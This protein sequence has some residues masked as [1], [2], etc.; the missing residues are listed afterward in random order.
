MI[1]QVN[2]FIETIRKVEEEGKKAQHD[3]DA[4]AKLLEQ[5][6]SGQ[7]AVAQK[8]KPGPDITPKLHAAYWEAVRSDYGFNVSLEHVAAKKLY[9]VAMTFGSFVSMTTALYRE[10]QDQCA[11]SRESVT[12]LLSAMG[13]TNQYDSFYGRMRTQGQKSLEQ[14]FRMWVLRFDTKFGSTTKREHEGLLWK[15]GTGV[16]HSWAQRYFVLSDNTLSYH[17]GIEDCDRREGELSLLCTTVKPLPGTGCFTIISPTKTYTLRAMTDYDRDEWIAVIQNNIEFL[18]NNSP[19]STPHRRSTAAD[20]WSPLSSEANQICADCG[21]ANPSWCCINWGVCVCIHCCGV[22]RSLTT[23]V[24]KPRSLTLDR[25]DAPTQ[26]IFD[27]IGNARANSILE[28]KVGDAKITDRATREEREAFIKRK[29]VQR[30]FVEPTPIDALQAV[31]QGD[32]LSIFKAVCSGN[33]ADD[34]NGYTALHCAASKGDAV[35]AL[36]VALNLPVT[37]VLNEGWSPLTYAAFYDHKTVA[38]A[39]IEA[40]CVS[41]AQGQVHPYEVALSKGYQEISLLFF[42]FWKGEIVPGKQFTPPVPYET[43]DT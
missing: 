13:S 8:K 27:V 40:G 37:D 26:R 4:Y 17:H 15:K 1:G 31:R 9:E 23:S 7:L 30:E 42:P 16:T 29:Y 34:R 38:S 3:Y 18:L 14:V 28:E 21:A 36:L 12:A 2:A 10:A 24:S 22:H 41:T 6:V 43:T 19:E 33:I 20:E 39:L 11:A 5:Y 25:L 35:M 32:Y